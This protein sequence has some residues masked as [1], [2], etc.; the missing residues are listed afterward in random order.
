MV[1]QRDI[2]R[3]AGLSQ[4]TVSLA[5]RR[6]PGLPAATIARV[7]AAA[8]GLGY[9]PDPLVSALMSQRQ[10]RKPGGTLRAKIAFLTAFP[11][12]DGWRRSRYI[13]DCYAGVAAACGPRGY[14]VEPRWLFEPLIGGR[15]LSRILWTQNFQG[16]VVAPLPVA[17][18]PMDIDWAQFSAVTL[19]Y[20]MADPV[21]HRAVDDHAAG[22]ERL[23]AE[24]DRRGYSRPGL[25]LRA[26]Q[27]IRTRHSRLG[28]FLAQR[29]HHPR[30]KTVPP[31]LLPEDRWGPAP[32]AAWLQRYR[33]D[34]ILTEEPEVPGALR[35]LGLQPPRDVG[36]AFFHQERPTSRLSGIRVL[37]EEVGRTAG[38]IL[39]RLIE[40]NERGVP[41]IPGTTLVS[42][43]AW[44]DGRTLRPA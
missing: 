30:W 42:S 19:D 34:V 26:P 21:L 13:S 4:A 8:A 7:H 12:R 35:R 10:A 27:D 20:S 40:T 44:N 43:L 17:N 33:P 31:L 32:F 36:L 25:V 29:L 18:P 15:R 38:N 39:M 16:L 1:T 23:L 6:H 11:T 3:A 22:L 2:A 5:L 28:F 14:L 24:I 37:A 9:R 41:R